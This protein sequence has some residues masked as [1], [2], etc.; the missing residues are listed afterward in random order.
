MEEKLWMAD[1][2]KELSWSDF[3]LRSELV[4]AVGDMGWTSPLPVQARALP[5]LLGETG[6]MIVQAPTGQGKTGAFAIAVLQSIVVDLPKPQA[7]IV[8]PTRE[9]VR[10]TLEEQL[11]PLATHLNVRCFMATKENYDRDMLPLATQVV[12]GTPGTLAGMAKF[13]KMP[14][15]DIKMLIIDEADMLLDKSA[16]GGR[17]DKGPSIQEQTI[18]LT[19]RLKKKC[20]I[21]MFSATYTEEAREFCRN[22]APHAHEVMFQSDKEQAPVQNVYQ[23][24][25]R[26]AKDGEKYSVLKTFFESMD[27]WNTLVFCSTIT[28]VQDLARRLRGELKIP[29]AEHHGQLSLDDRDMNIEKFRS[30]AIRVLIC[31]DVLGRGVDIPNINFVVNYQ[32]PRMPNGR[33]DIKEFIHRVGRAGR[34]E[35]K[36]IAVSFTASDDE[37]KLLTVILSHFPDLHVEIIS[38]PDDPLFVQK[39]HKIREMMEKEAA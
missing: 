24:R 37:E 1:E 8:C 31:T 23:F 2:P 15:E 32:P 20:R 34:V 29:V 33:A 19:N 30:G 9:L 13:G 36:G 3:G 21:F 5:V 6:H 18:S 12:V 26:A 14:V 17:K 4:R 22:V 38:G 10:Q 35:R 27:L 11:T 7:V 25:I 28:Q 16:K 39:L